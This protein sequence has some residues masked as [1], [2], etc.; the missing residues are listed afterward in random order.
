[1]TTI[2][3]ER[4]RVQLWNERK[5]HATV[6][7]KCGICPVVYLTATV[8]SVFSDDS[9][10]IPDNDGRAGSANN[11]RAPAYTREYTRPMNYGGVT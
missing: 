5:G 3:S 10:R 11:F 6:N 4:W 7:Y 1:M 2:Y 9:C 8:S